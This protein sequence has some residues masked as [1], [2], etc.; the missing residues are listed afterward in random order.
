[1]RIKGKVTFWDDDKGYGFI[2]PCSGGDR[3]FLH[4]TALNQRLG[5]PELGQ[6]V[7]YTPATD[8]EGRHRASEVTLPGERLVKRERNQPQLFS[9][10]LSLLFLG[11]VVAAVLYSH[12]HP[13]FLVLYLVASVI[14]FFAY[15][16]DKYAAKN[17]RWRVSEN[18]LH[19]FSLLGGWP[20]ALLAQQFLRHK[21]QKPLFRFNFWTTVLLNGLAFAWLFTPPGVRTTQQVIGLFW[22]G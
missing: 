14:T 12:L 19:M 1:M 16:E 7:T 21:T 18:T 11:G 22:G 3:V 8:K 20:G 17:D 13:V 9:I 6:L 4:I 15:A 5:R 2:E 10:V